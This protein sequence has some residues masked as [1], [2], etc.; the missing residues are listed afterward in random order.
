MV[1]VLQPIISQHLQLPTPA[2]GLLAA[3][4]SVHP[5][6][7]AYRKPFGKNE[8]CY[9]PDD[10]SQPISLQDV[11]SY[12]LFNRT[13]AGDPEPDDSGSIDPTSGAGGLGIPTRM[14]YG[15]SVPLGYLWS[16]LGRIDNDWVE[17]VKDEYSLGDYP[18]DTFRYRDRKQKTHL[19][20]PADL[21]ALGRHFCDALEHIERGLTIKDARLK[22]EPYPIETLSEASFELPSLADA[23]R[24]Y[25]RIE[26]SVRR[27]DEY[28]HYRMQQSQ[29]LLSGDTLPVQILDIEEVSDQ[30][31]YITGRLRYDLLFFKPAHA[32]AVKRACRVKSGDGSSSGEWMVATPWSPGRT[33][34]VMTAPYDIETG[35]QSTIQLLDL[36][37]NHVEFTMKNFWGSDAEF[38]RSHKSWTTNSGKGQNSPYHVLLE[39]GEFLF[40]DPQTDDITAKRIDSALEYADEN[41]LHN[42]LE[43]IRHGQEPAP[44]TDLFEQNSLNGF[45]EFMFNEIEPESLPSDEQ[46]SFIT[47]HEAQIV[48]LQGPPGTGKTDGAF[49]PALLGRAWGRSQRGLPL[50]GLITAPSNTAIDELLDST[51]ELY[52]DCIQFDSSGDLKSIELIR[53]A[54][55]KPSDA[56]D[57]VTYLDYNDPDDDPELTR[58]GERLHDTTGGGQGK[59]S[60]FGE[61]TDSSS[62]Q[63]LVFA[64]PSRAWKLV[65]EVTPGNDAKSVASQSVWHLLAVDEASMMTV[66]QFLLAGASLRSESQ[67]LVGGDHR[68]L[69]PVQK[70]DWDNERRRSIR[71]TVPYLSTLDYLRVLRGEE[72]DVLGEDT[73]KAWAGQRDP[74]NVEIPFVQLST[75]YRFGHTTANLSQAAIYQQDQINYTAA[76]PS[77]PLPAKADSPSSLRTALS[78][79]APITLITYSATGS[80][81]QSNPIEEAIAAALINARPPASSAGVVTPH[82]AQK[83]RLQTTIFDSDSINATRDT[84]QIETV[85]RFQGGEAKLMVLSGTVAD[86]QYIR[87][88]DDFLLTETRVNVAMTRHKQTLVVIAPQS[89]LGYIPTD[90]DL[91]DDATIW[92]KV[93]D[94][95]GEAPT[96]DESPVWKDTLQSF[97][98][99]QD[100][101]S[102][103]PDVEHETEISV[104]CL[105]DIESGT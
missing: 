42:C 7:D 15:A 25:L 43:A 78:S 74:T 9:D 80:Y 85:N 35:V 28:A 81:Q 21:K 4:E 34:E 31:V 37:E 97:V 13:V 58:L 44:T 12:R 5:P 104:Y 46:R 29:R 69:P 55:D 82:N 1:S 14:R 65:N 59:I 8:W 103:V 33:D 61:S 6:T 38:S 94:W 77:D 101:L 66:P 20:T 105:S 63:T 41:A 11:F 26:H 67:V 52:T 54:S 76:N 102:R 70:H 72:Q 49:A 24:E 48:G 17:S 100:L 95:S 22:K 60:D 2:V 79:E 86:P 91:Y 51:A 88:E 23:S 62:T 27:S 64:T 93:A 57:C 89:L 92:K 99:D 68:Q 50:A 36:D 96:T 90:T 30:T 47:E 87:K 98:H 71:S 56:S 10:G 73:A 39:K 84:V 18:L 83:S 3:Y 16:A 75:T 53:I 45:S 19:I 40:L 32:E